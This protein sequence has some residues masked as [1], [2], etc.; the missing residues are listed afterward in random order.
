[1][2]QHLI[3]LHEVLDLFWSPFTDVTFTPQTERPATPYLFE[4]FLQ[5]PANFEACREY[6]TNWQGYLICV[7]HSNGVIRPSMT[8]HVRTAALSIPQEFRSYMLWTLLRCEALSTFR[9]SQDH[10]N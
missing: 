8:E 6:V 10:A 1:M 5:T 3:P 7:N 2:N 4:Q 9:K